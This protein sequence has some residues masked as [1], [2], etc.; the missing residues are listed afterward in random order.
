MSVVPRIYQLSKIQQLIDLNENLVNF[1]LN[2]KITSKNGESFLASVNTQ[3]SLDSGETIDFQVAKGSISGNIV[4]DENVYKSYFLILKSEE[5]VEVE[6]LTELKEIAPKQ[7]PMINHQP[8][9][10]QQPHPMMQQQPIMKKK[11]SFFT[12]NNILLI[13]F[14]FLI[15]IYLGWLL[16]KYY[17]QQ[18]DSPQIENKIENILDGKIN[19]IENI[20]DGKINE[21]KNQLDGTTEKTT[22]NIENMLDGK[23]NKLKENIDGS[24]NT[25]VNK[26]KENIDGSSNI[27]VNKLKEN[28]DGSSNIIVNKLKEN[29]DGTTDNIVSKLKENM[30]GNIDVKIDKL[31]E[32]FT[33]TVETLGDKLSD[34]N[35]KMKVSMNQQTEGIKSSIPLQSEG[36]KSSSSLLSKLQNLKIKS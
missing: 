27:I 14:G 8:M 30:D 22:S 34:L 25:I 28:I 32:N 6:V 9:M 35:E 31:K 20:L 13:G 1:E 29:I 24:S 17:R 33:G 16:Y 12:F 3:E 5:P 21:I 11:K 4:S 7:P 2:F 23:I 10:M 19:N 26:L 15:A 36:I 18:P